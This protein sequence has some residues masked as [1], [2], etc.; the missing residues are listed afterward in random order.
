MTYEI[1]GFVGPTKYPKGFTAGTP[2]GQLVSSDGTDWTV[3]VPFQ[4]FT[5]INVK[6]LKPVK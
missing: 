6:T 2:C 1:E 3:S 5:N 4:C